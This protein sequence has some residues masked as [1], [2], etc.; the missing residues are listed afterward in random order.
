MERCDT[1]GELDYDDELG[2]D[3]TTCEYCEDRAFYSSLGVSVKKSAQCDKCKTMFAIDDKAYFSDC[4]EF[5]TKCCDMLLCGEEGKSGCLAVHKVIK[6]KCG[7]KSCSFSNPG[8]TCRKCA[9]DKRE[10]KEQ[11]AMLADRELV[12]SLL[13]KLTSKALKKQVSSMLKE[14]PVAKK[15]K[16]AASKKSTPNV[17]EEVNLAPKKIAG[18]KAKP[19]PKKDVTKKTE[20]P[21]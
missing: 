7:H 3:R 2:P 12:E 10:D 5:I 13:P 18:A 4:E 1:C 15:A 9:L 11:A 14:L 20:G 21:L 19:A 6:F 8:S 17:K 16:V